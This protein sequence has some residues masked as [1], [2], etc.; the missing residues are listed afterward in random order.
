MK[1]SHKILIPVFSVL[2]AASIA[3]VVFTMNGT[4]KRKAAPSGEVENGI[5]TSTDF[6]QLNSAAVQ[7][8]YPCMKSDIDSVFYSAGADGIIKF[9]EFDGKSFSDYNG[10]VKTIEVAPELTYEK[11]PITIS[12]IEKDGKTLGYGIFTN[13]NNPE[14]TLYP[15]VFAKL[16]DAPSVYGLKGK[17]LLLNINPDEA[18][19][20]NKTYSEVFNVDMSTGGLGRVFSQRDRQSDKTGKLT[21]RW[22]ILTD[23]FLNSAQKK[24]ACISGRLYNSDTAVYDVFNLNKSMSK[25]EAEKIYGTFLRENAKDGGYIYLKKTSTGFKSVKFI[26]QEKEIARFDG[27]I[28]KDFVFSGDWVYAAKERTFTNLVTGAKIK[29]DGVEAIDM[30]A[31]NADGSKIAAAANYKNQAFF[32]IDKEGNVDG[33]SGENFFNSNIRNICFTGNDVVFTTATNENGTCTNYLTK[34]K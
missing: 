29:T 33:Y 24:A 34:I 26:A 3:L 28:N 17:M 15:Y 21:E 20:Y 19:S 5:Y 25:P 18:Y 22:H 30:F 10:I 8:Q 4:L 23:G 11:I 32:V 1:T 6:A 9:Y 7:S 16:T 14:V 2:L 31:V 13:K 12:Y 27:D